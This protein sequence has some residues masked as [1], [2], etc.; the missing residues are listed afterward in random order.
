[1]ATVL[2]LWPISCVAVFG[3]VNDVPL[4]DKSCMRNLYLSAAVFLLLS[5]I[6]YAAYGIYKKRSL[7]VIDILCNLL[8]WTF[9][10][11]FFVVAA[12]NMDLCSMDRGRIKRTSADIKY[13]AQQIEAYKIA[14]SS[15]PV[16]QSVD[17][18]KHIITDKIPEHD[19]WNNQLDVISNAA[20]YWIISRGADGKRE[21][22]DLSMYIPQTTDCLECDIVMHNGKFIQYP[23]ILNGHAGLN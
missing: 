8:W 10:S 17:A 6:L 9:F 16:A 5:T 18:L 14:N 7:K 12:P 21:F 11:L 23:K 15:Y 3:L 1:M 2:L 13:L 22:E 19:G 4:S 20:D